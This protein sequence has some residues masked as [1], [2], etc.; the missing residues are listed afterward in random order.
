MGY[1]PT[2][3]KNVKKKRLMNKQK[4]ANSNT[5]NLDEK[6]QVT[7]EQKND[8][9]KQINFFGFD[10]KLFIVDLRR[11]GYATLAILIIL[12]VITWMK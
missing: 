12:G 2:R 4:I 9:I 1:R 11:T 10:P 5:K 6:L 8:T 3:H 7:I